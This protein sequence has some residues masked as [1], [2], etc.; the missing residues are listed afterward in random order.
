MA[1]RTKT[2]RYPLSVLTASV[3]STVTATFATI[4]IDIPETNTV[5]FR[6]CW[7]E[8]TC[9]GNET[10]TMVAVTSATT[11]GK[12]GAA[13]A[14]TQTGTP[15]YSIPQSKR[16]TQ[17]YFHDLTSHFVSN[18]SGTSMTFVGTMAQTGPATI[19]HTGELVI[20]YSFD[21]AS[22]ANTR[23]KTAYIPLESNTGVLTST[24]ASVGSTQIPNLSTFCPEASK[25]FKKV[26]LRIL[27]SEGATNTTTFALAGALDAAGETQLTGT[28][29]QNVGTDT[30]LKVIWD[31]TGMTTNATHD[32][33]LRSNATT[34]RINHP[35]VVL[36]V[37]YTYDH[38]TTTS[39]LNSV[40]IDLDVSLAQ[41][42][43]GASATNK[44]RLYKKFFVEEASPS[45]VQSGVLISYFTDTTATDVGFNIACGSQTTRAYTANTAANLAG[46]IHMIQR[47]DSGGA[48]GAGISI[49]RGEN[50]FQCDVFRS[51]YASALACIVGQAT[52]FLNY[53]STLHASGAEVHNHTVEKLVQST[54]TSG[55]DGIGS[56]VATTPIQETTYWLTAIGMHA[57]HRLQQTEWGVNYALEV[58]S[59]EL[60]GAGWRHIMSA[61]HYEGVQWFE[62]STD[63]SM[64]FDRY[65][66]DPVRE[67]LDPTASRKF[68][69]QG[70]YNAWGGMTTRAT[71]HA[72]TFSV[73]TPTGI[74][75]SASGTITA[76][77]FRADTDEIVGSNTRAGDGTITVTVYDNTASNYYLNCVDSGT[78][79]AGRSIVGTPT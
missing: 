42:V 48:Q 73:S 29:T 34:S 44:S 65:A 72:I 20:T 39:L 60:E 43:S 69:C 58:L 47:I 5:T 17:I 4:T 46:Q 12:L 62:Y 40:Q 14:A 13:T 2:I 7:T 51:S 55:A 63:L 8:N 37:T 38:S 6:S 21:D 3:A 67:R 19:N 32:L 26:W 11:T 16:Q 45:L 52:L 71:Y 18:W 31:I 27:A 22:G 74:T 56:S 35:A 78:G 68:K 33:K 70:F 30:A 79:N 28:L 1:I 36:C 59:G 9:R 15:S 49:A 66:G 75:L 24:L 57:I 54:I 61:S 64:Y 53:T 77:A 41:W 25:T 50:T 76:K 10:T 23:V